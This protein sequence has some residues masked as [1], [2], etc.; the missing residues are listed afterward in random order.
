MTPRRKFSEIL[1]KRTLQN[2]CQIIPAME[3]AFNKMAG[4]NSR[5]AFLL[6]R[7]FHKRKLLKRCFL[8][9]VLLRQLVFGTFSEKNL[10]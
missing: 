6:K 3:S 9:N 1:E 7:S 8:K 5:T 4:M 10:W 2:P